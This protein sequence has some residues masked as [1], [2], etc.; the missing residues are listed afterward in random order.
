MKGILLISHGFYAKELRDSLKMIAGNVDNIYVACLETTDGPEEFKAK[1]IEQEK[2]LEVFEEV[3]VFADLMGGSPCNTASQ[4][5]LANKKYEIIAGMNFP[6]I[7]T[8][9]LEPNKSIDDLVSQGQQSI[10]DIRKYLSSMSISDE[11]D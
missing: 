7:L 8:A 3:I 4:H 2:A 9:L 5:F 6:L 11:E 1:L 10:I